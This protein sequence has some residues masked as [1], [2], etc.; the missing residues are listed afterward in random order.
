MTDDMKQFLE[1]MQVDR[2]NLF[3]EETVTDLRAATFRRLI[4]IHADGTTDTSRAETYV[5]STQIMS[6]QGPL[7]IQAE[8]P[9]ATLAE[10]MDQFPAAMEQAVQELVKQAEE[11]RRQESSRIVVP[12]REDPKI[13]SR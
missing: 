6:P 12:G 7:P 1:Q 3:R 10:A 13:F 4:P 2:G 8:I 11:Y 9:A 5:G